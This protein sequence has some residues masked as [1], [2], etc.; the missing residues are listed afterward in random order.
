MSK[1][2]HITSFIY[3]ERNDLVAIHD[4]VVHVLHR[5]YGT[6]LVAFLTPGLDAAAT[7]EY[8]AA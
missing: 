4:D 6:H 8:D 3:L 1:G 2:S 7:G 5:G